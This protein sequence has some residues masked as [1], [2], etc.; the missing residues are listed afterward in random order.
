MH[1]VIKTAI[2]CFCIGEILKE[3]YYHGLKTSFNKKGDERPLISF[4]M[5]LAINI[6]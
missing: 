4:L 2:I 6:H 3:F 1:T 5:F